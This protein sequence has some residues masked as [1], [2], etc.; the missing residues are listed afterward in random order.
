[1][2]ETYCGKSCDECKYRESLGCPGCTAGPGAPYSGSCRLASCC[3]ERGHERCRMCLDRGSCEMLKRRGSMPE[4][5]AREEAER[6]A[7]DARNREK[8]AFL[9]KWLWALFMLI[10]PAIIGDVIGIFPGIVGL[11]GS[12]ISL[13]VSITYGVILLRLSRESRNYLIAGICYFAAAVL[14]FAS[15]PFLADENLFNENIV[16]VLVMVF[17]AVPFAFL[18]E[19]KE[20]NAHRAVL[21][22]I[23]DELAEKWRK[24]IFWYIFSIAGRVLGNMIPVFGGLILLPASIANIAVKILK[25]VYLHRTALAFRE[26]YL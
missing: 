10:V 18:S 7:F 23:D 13:A 8:C 2:S 5:R 6:A 1:M 24:L 3:R 19:F 17:L 25:L 11:L 15:V 9:G 12:V 22:G 4:D 21:D 26:Y 16:I 14:M 20:Y